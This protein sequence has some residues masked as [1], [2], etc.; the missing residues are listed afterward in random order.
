L[1]RDSGVADA[2]TDSSEYLRPVQILVSIV[3][4]ALVPLA[5]EGRDEFIWVALGVSISCSCEHTQEKDHKDQAHKYVC[6]LP[7]LSQPV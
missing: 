1:T 3:D 2:G 6:A 5:V 4:A 7:V